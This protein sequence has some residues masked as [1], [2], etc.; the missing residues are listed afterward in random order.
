MTEKEAWYKKVANAIIDSETFDVTKASG[1]VTIYDMIGDYIIRGLDPVFRAA[2]DAAP[3][4][5]GCF[6]PAVIYLR[7]IGVKVYIVIPSGQR[8]RVCVTTNPDYKILGERAADLDY[9]RVEVKVTQAVNSATNRIS[10]QHQDKA[11]L[12]LDSTQRCLQPISPS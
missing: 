8:N 6:D 1:D 7:S 2:I 11:G 3:R 4:V 9:D 12:F 10:S 5:K